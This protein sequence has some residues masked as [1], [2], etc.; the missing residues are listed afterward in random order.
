MTT[1]KYHPLCKLF[2]TLEK[3]ELT[4]LANDIKTNGLVGSITLYEG[5]ILDGRNRHMAC[6]L[7]GVEP[8]FREFKG[9]DPLSF[10]ISVN[11]HR[12]H[13]T[14]SQ[15]AGIAAKLSE[16]PMGEYTQ[17][18]T[19]LEKSADLPTKD[20]HLPLR[21]IAQLPALSQQGAADALNV[22]RRSVVAAVQLEK[23]KPGTADDLINGKTTLSKAA[24]QPKPEP[25]A[26]R[27][28]LGLAI[29]E[30]IINSWTH[31]E[32]EAK[33]ALHLISQVRSAIR[34][35]QEEDDPGYREMNF[36]STMAHL[37]NAYSDIKRAVPYAVCT[38]CQGLLANK[39][40]FCKGRGYISEFSWKQHVPSEIKALRI[41]AIK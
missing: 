14:I 12:R 24:A 41:K 33:G 25:P 26:R 39:C 15:R 38:T 3:D 31:M 36:S 5:Q 37:D 4:T 17:N 22:S 16:K 10:V 29:P 34:K 21:K 40:A 6:L 28:G 8:K 20:G 35:A 7:A 30:K 32:S 13:L 18:E 19:R 9:D 23:Q 1:P 27:D 2:P 11:L